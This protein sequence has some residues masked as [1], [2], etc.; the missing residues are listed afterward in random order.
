M[1]K[2]NFNTWVNFILDFLDFF[3]NQKVHKF[4]LTSFWTF[5]LNNQIVHTFGVWTECK[6][7]LSLKTFKF[8]RTN[9]VLCESIFYKTNKKPF[10]NLVRIHPIK[11]YRNIVPL[12]L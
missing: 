3:G 11:P 9:C 1:R 2:A 7:I 10:K 8:G 4:G 5:W 12:N 6:A